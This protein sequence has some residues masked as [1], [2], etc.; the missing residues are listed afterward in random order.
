Q[1]PLQQPPQLLLQQQRQ[2][3]LQQL[4]RP[5]P[6][7][8]L[9]LLHKQQRRPSGLSRSL[10]HLQDSPSHHHHHRH[11]RCLDLVVRFASHHADL[12][13]HGADLGDHGL[14]QGERGADEEGNG[15]D[16]E[17][18]GV[19]QE[20]HGVGLWDNGEDEDGSFWVKGK[21]NSFSNTLRIFLAFSSAMY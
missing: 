14:E 8:L 9:Q 16:Q 12:W 11:H 19:D 10:L 17:D 13:D 4:L 5:H 1:L 21:H 20:D 6:Q 15:V 7:Q 18:H 2:L 3:H